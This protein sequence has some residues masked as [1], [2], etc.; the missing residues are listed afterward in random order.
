MGCGKVEKKVPA[1]VRRYYAEAA[2]RLIDAELH[3][4]NIRAKYPELF[5]TAKHSVAFFWKGSLNDLVE[6]VSALFYS[7][8]I[9]DESGV[10]LSYLKL[11]NSAGELFGVNISRPY[12]KRGRLEMRKKGVTPFLDKL[13]ALIIKNTTADNQ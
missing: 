13:K 5:V 8:M 1:A 4:L 2:L 11:I 9:T 12:D 10:P 3:L 7:R 6:V